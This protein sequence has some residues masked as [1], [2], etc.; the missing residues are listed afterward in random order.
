MMKKLA[1]IGFQQSYTYFTWRNTKSELISYVSE[2]AGEMSNYYRPNFFA[3]TPDI[4]PYY[5][6]SGG[7]TGFIIRATLAAT[8]SSNWGIYSGFELCEFAALPGREEYLDSE[9]YQLKPRDY[10]APGNI[11]T[12]IRILNHIRREHRALQDF[13]NILFLEA[14]NENVLAY[15][16]MTSSRDDFI[17]VLVNLDPHHAQSCS[18]EV[19]LWEFGLSDWDSIQTEDLVQGNRFVLYGKVH[20]ITLDPAINPV[21]IWRLHGP[22]RTESTA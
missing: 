15:A 3:N 22:T 4:N 12:H 18:Y 8:L 11:K 21:V 14:A 7:R 20:E 10:D 1:K 9:K 16:R 5:L 17:L 2:L 19:P 13:R 6:Q